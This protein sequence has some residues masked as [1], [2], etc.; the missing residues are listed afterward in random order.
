VPIPFSPMT[1]GTT[2]DL[3]RVE[4]LKGPQ[5]TLFGENATGGAINYIAEK[6]TDHFEAGGDLSYGR[7]SDLKFDAYASG[8]ITDTLDGRIAI[9][10]HNSDAW[11]KGYGPQG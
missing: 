6:P 1:L 3:Q 7:F 11:Q 9:Q 10:T 5:G 8:P 2:L 4:V